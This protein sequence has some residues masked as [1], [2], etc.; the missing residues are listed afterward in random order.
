M[1]KIF[2]AFVALACAISSCSDDDD[3]V[4]SAAET[5]ELSAES[6]PVGPDGAEVEIVVTSSAAWRIAGDCPWARPSAVA[7]NSGDKVVFT[8]DANETG[9]RREATFK[10]F[11]GAT[12]VPF[13]IVSDPVFVLELLS[14]AEYSFATGASSLCLRFNSNI[15]ELQ[16]EIVYENADPED[17]PWIEYNGI[18]QSFGSTA[19]NFSIAENATYLARQAQIVVCGMDKRFEIAVA[20][21]KPSFFEWNAEDKYAYEDIEAHDFEVEVRTNL[22]Y[23]VSL[24][25]KCDWITMDK[26]LVSE[27]KGL[28]TE[29]LTFHV[30]ASEK[31]RSTQ[32]KVYLDG[33]TWNSYAS[34]SVSQKDP[35]MVLLEI[36]DAKFLKFLKK[37]GYIE[38]VGDGMYT[39]SEEGA[40]ATE[41]DLSYEYI[42]DFT[43]L[44]YFTELTAIDVTGNNMTSFD[45][46]GLTKVED[47]TI[48][49]CSDC[50]TIVLG[51]NPILQLAVLNSRYDYVDF[52][53]LTVSGEVV[54]EFYSSCSRSYD[55]IKTVDLSGCPSLKVIECERANLG[56]LILAKA[57]EGIQI[58][59]TTNAESIE[60]K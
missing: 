51:A 13:K 30:A 40:A 47:L 3:I 60:Y 22:D 17:M 29:K 10:F 9:A 2:L 20:Q 8:V 35:N 43:G 19:L 26:S 57:L 15:D 59:L 16:C 18:S 48:D 21:D 33:D 55:E 1:K 53:T 14:D 4:T 49:S 27:V 6:A 56:T 24:D 31:S 5:L 12:V 44:A 42:S 36:P 11:A 34:F 23:E 58:N 25:E 37:Y 38:E 32:V 7:G 41:F 28:R 54:E 45:I 39:V 50:Q 52:E 46:S